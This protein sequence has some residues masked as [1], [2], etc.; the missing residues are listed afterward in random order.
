M[1][2]TPAFQLLP[3]P[4]PMDLRGR[5]VLVLGFGDTGFSLARWAEAQGARVRAADTRAKFTADDSC[6]RS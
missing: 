3:R 1:M 5:L 6:S 4:A 2:R